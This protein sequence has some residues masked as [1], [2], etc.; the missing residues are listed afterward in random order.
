MLSPGMVITLAPVTKAPNVLLVRPGF[1]IPCEKKS[2][3]ETL[4]ASL[5]G[6]PLTLI[7]ESSLKKDYYSRKK[8]DKMNGDK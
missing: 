2:S 4:A 7:P 3:E 6:K 5:Q 8:K 1:A